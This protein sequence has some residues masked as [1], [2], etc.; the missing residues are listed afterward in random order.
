MSK[1]LYIGSLLFGSLSVVLF[2]VCSGEQQ[3]RPSFA[4]VCVSL[5]FVL[6]FFYLFHN[7]DKSEGFVADIFKSF[8][9]IFDQA[10][11]YVLLAL[12]IKLLY[13]SGQPYEMALICWMGF[14][15]LVHTLVKVMKLSSSIPYDL[16][17]SGNTLAIENQTLL[18]QCS[19]KIFV[20][21]QWPVFLLYAY[22]I[23]PIAA[24]LLLFLV[25]ILS[26]PFVVKSF[27]EGVRLFTYT[28]GIK[29][30]L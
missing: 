8:A 3:S 16:C 22:L 23:A 20:D 12:G 18:Q 10:V 4:L 9:P 27:K 28:I 5:Y 7:A 2:I 11:Y 17:F 25:A 30:K 14:F 13:S 29:K 1:I 26:V 19:E 24:L 15:I 21:S 6:K